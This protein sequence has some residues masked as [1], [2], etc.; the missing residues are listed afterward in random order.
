MARV[1]WLA[2]QQAHDRPFYYKSVDSGEVVWNIPGITRQHAHVEWV[3]V[4][5][6]VMLIDLPKEFQHYEGQAGTIVN[7]CWAFAS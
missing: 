5:S 3:Q 6:A 4:G 1:K 7:V 2:Q